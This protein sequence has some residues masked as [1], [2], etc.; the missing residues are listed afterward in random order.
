MRLRVILLAAGL[1]L[2]FL[3]GLGAWITAPRVVAVSPTPAGLDLPR[4][5]P[6]ELTFS[7]PMNSESLLTHLQIEPEITG[8]YTWDDNR[9]IFTPEQSWPSGQT[10]TV[11]MQAGARAMGGL[12]LPIMSRTTWSFQVSEL[13][14]T[15]LWPANDLAD[16]YALNPLSGEVIQLTENAAVQ[17]YAVS[18]DGRTLYY[19]A[20][21]LRGGGVIVRLQL[22]PD[23]GLGKPA[24]QTLV[25]CENA[26]CRNPTA[27]ADGRWLAYEQIPESG[28]RTQIEIMLLDLSSG[29]SEPVGIADH[30]GRYPTWSSNGWLAFYDLT[31][32]AYR[33]I[34]PDSGAVKTLPNQ[35]GEPGSWRPDGKAFLASEIFDESSPQLVSAASGHMLLYELEDSANILD[36]THE[37]YLEDTGG[38]FSPKGHQIAFTRKFLDPQ[39]WTT[40]RQLWIMDVDPVQPDKS[41]ARQIT[42]DPLYNHYSLAWSPD[43]DQL[44]YM[45]FNQSEITQ[46]P[47]LWLVDADG[48]DPIRLVIGGYA[49]HWIP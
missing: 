10:I 37:Y 16:L 40:G 9:L 47:E 28:G 17:D 14:L 32:Q 23:N 39:R 33:A 12:G 38:V 20:D 30:P 24:S 2:L 45:R 6:I 48:T 44:A 34:H 43:G 36:L 29:E 49:P 19:T 42:N 46:E 18:P 21:L 26:V 11:T 27:S 41:N 7:Q 25:T 15:Y 22:Q 1:T 31:D 8:Q 3:I 5:I 13:L 4:D 35:A